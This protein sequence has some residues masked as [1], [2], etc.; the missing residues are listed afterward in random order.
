MHALGPS[1][2]GL[3]KI[4]NILLS[5]L[6]RCD[7]QGIYLVRESGII[8]SIKAAWL[9]KSIAAFDKG[10]RCSVLVLVFEMVHICVLRSTCC[11]RIGGASS[12]SLPMISPVRTAVRGRLMMTILAGLAE[13][14]RELIRARTSAGRDR[15]KAQGVRFGRKPKLTA[16]QRA[17][18]LKLLDAGEPQSAVAKVLGVDQSTISRLATRSA[19]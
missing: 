3:P 15:A 5:R 9:Q 7:A 14:E 10:T 16:H 11:Q 2:E 8:L 18:A 13:F 19:A 1:R 12:R 4:R 17:H 6:A